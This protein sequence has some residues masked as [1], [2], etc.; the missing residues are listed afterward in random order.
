[1]VE[2]EEFD[3]FMV[4]MVMTSLYPILP[5]LL[6][7]L[8]YI[9][10]NFK[11]Q[12]TSPEDSATALKVVKLLESRD[13]TVLGASSAFIRQDNFASR[14][15][16][17]VFLGLEFPLG[18]EYSLLSLSVGHEVVT[19]DP[20]E[21]SRDK[22]GV[23][24]AD[25]QLKNYLIEAARSF[26]SSLKTPDQGDLVRVDFRVNRESQTVEVLRVNPIPRIFSPDGLTIDD[27]MVEQSV[28]GGHPAMFDLLVATKRLGYGAALINQ[29]IVDTYAMYTSVYDQEVTEFP[30]YRIL[31][32]LVSEFDWAGTVLDLACGTGLLGKL[33]HEKGASFKIVGVDLSPQMTASPAIRKYYQSP[34]TIGTMQAAIMQPAQFDHLACFGALT[35]LNDVEFIA[36]L[37]RMFMVAQKSI[38]FDLEDVSEE[39]MQKMTKDS[40][41]LPCY[42]HAKAWENF[43]IPAGWKVVHKEYGLLYHDAH[44]TKCDVFDYMIRLE[45]C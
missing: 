43:K 18:T 44:E 20:L 42:N 1:M 3:M 26:V 13:K 30:Y 32:Q 39:Y 8:G 14:A 22:V 9:A 2:E 27:A 33:L 15:G 31:Q 35:Y 4:S 12:W 21:C 17:K 37:L 7:M 29:R 36:V 40:S 25:A 5:L 38:N 34:V 45:K 16:S 28:P 41:I 11:A 10:A 6:G 23:P 19:F 24:V